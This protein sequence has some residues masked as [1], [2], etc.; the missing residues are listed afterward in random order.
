MSPVGVERQLPGR[1]LVVVMRIQQLMDKMNM[2]HSS[3]VV[4]NPP[5]PFSLRTVGK[6]YNAEK[7][8]PLHGRTKKY[9]NKESS[10]VVYP[11]VIGNVQEAYRIVNDGAYYIQVCQSGTSICDQSDSYFKIV[12]SPTTFKEQVKC[13]FNGSNTEQTCYTASGE[14]QIGCSGI[15]AC[16]I[17]VA[18]YKG[19]QITWKSSCGGCAYTNMDGVS[20]YADFNFSVTPSITLLSPNGGETWIKGT[21]QAIKWQ[22]NTG[23]ISCPVGTNC[24]LP[25][26]YYDLKLVSYYPPCTGQVCPA[27]PYLA[28]YTIATGISGSLTSYSWSVG[29]IMNTYGNG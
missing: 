26:R 5:S 28:P 14:K 4:S 16:I 17:D 20:E 11:W 9:Y 1:V 13:V 3:A 15:N 19:E 12:T 8:I 21:T 23:T 27:Y 7:A 2:P 25:V 18:G 24:I 6:H 22:D 10:N 29:K